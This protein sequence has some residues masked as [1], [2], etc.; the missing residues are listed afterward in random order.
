MEQAVGYVRI[1]REDQ[2]QNSIP[3]QVNDITSYCKRN[4]LDLVQIFTDNGQSGF[5]FQR[6]EWQ[7]VE[8]YIKKNKAVKYLVVLDME[9]FSRA[10]LVDALQ[11]MDEIQKRISVKI[12]TVTD[13]VN[14]DI[15]DF[16]TDLRRIIQLL[17]SNY[18]LKKI[19]K[20]TSDGLYT[21]MSSGRWVNKAPYGFVN[22]RDAEGRPLIGIDEDKAYAVRLVFR[23]YLQGFEL[24]EIRKETVANGV[25]LKG[26]SAIRRMLS[27]PLYAGLIQLPKH[28]DY[29]AKLIKGMHPPIVSENDY[30][31]V[32]DRLA[33]KT[34]ATQKSDA[35]YLKGFM[36]CQHCGSVLSSDNV[37]NKR[38]NYYQYYLCKTH[39]KY[40]SAAKLHRL[41]DDI[42][43]VLSLPVDVI[44]E[45]RNILSGLL[46]Q[47]LV[48]R[49]GDIMRIK[50]NLEK[51]QQKID[52]T[53]EKYLLQPDIPQA[54]YSRAIAGLKAD[55]TRLQQQLAELGSNAERYHS[56]MDT[57]LPMLSD[58]KALFHSMPA[59]KKVQFLQV[60]FGQ[61][62]TVVDG[63][64]R[65]PS[66]HFLF[67]DK[68]VILKEKKLLYVE[69]LNS[70]WE[71]TPGSSPYGSLFE[72]INRLWE[73]LVA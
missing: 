64:I 56:I 59:Y 57:L 16:G 24:D 47:H 46:E 44:T 68:A 39:R 51:V 71:N 32:Q 19:R 15:E 53:Q 37:K 58:T 33:G 22:I 8:Q 41:F 35:V 42:L 36:R 52:A 66:L 43:D 49:G 45:T 73:V 20:R 2:S 31:L 9:R 54:V 28:G 3:G 69:Q 7:Q 6:R 21:A 70:I 62:A 17:F 40:I 18:E 4:N 10:N 14:L 67:A 30:W 38:G 72:Q 12:L 63:V 60:V 25:K 48:N 5:N 61:G 55:E 29:P 13:P 23:K 34:R 1:S 26:N 50:M 11:K 65:T 27:N